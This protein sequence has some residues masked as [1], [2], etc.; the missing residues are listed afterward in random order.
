MEKTKNLPQDIIIVKKK[1][2]VLTILHAL[3]HY[4]I[5]KMQTKNISDSTV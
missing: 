1:I 3:A 2:L 4:L 5:N